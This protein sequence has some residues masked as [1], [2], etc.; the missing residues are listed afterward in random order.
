MQ[1]WA[2]NSLGYARTRANSCVRLD[3][4]KVKLASVMILFLECKIKLMELKKRVEMEVTE[5]MEM[6]EEVVVMGK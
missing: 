6:T 3:G 5:V 2:P 4:Y 1:S